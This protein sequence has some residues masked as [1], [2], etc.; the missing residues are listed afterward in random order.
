MASAK[1]LIDLFCGG[2]GFSHGAHEAGAVVVLAIDS[3]P[4]AL[5]QHY[6]NWP[7]CRHVLMKLGHGDIDDFVEQ[8]RCFV[9][10]LDG[11]CHIHGSPPCQGFTSLNTYYNN[12]LGR[13]RHKLGPEGDVNY[14]KTCLTY[15]YLEVVRRLQPVSWSMENVP[16]ALKFLKFRTPWIFETDGVYVHDKVFGYECGAPTIRAR[17]I[18]ST[19]DL[20][21][22]RIINCPHRKKL[23]E[24]LVDHLPHLEDEFSLDRRRIAV[25][26][27]TWNYSAHSYDGLVARPINFANGEGLR[28]ITWNAYAVVASPGPVNV[29]VKKELGL[30]WTLARELTEDERLKLMGFSS[31]YKLCTSSTLRCVFYESV[32]SSK[33]VKTSRLNVKGIG[34]CSHRQVIGNAVC[35]GVAKMILERFLS[36]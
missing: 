14:E 15:W 16:Y 8:L 19:S 33:L 5:A 35:P 34:K 23:Q 12:G 36:I 32:C 10:S 28:P 3:N 13:D 31:S 11:P 22:R 29:Y 18:V 27:Q 2:G 24:P 4:K 7:D 25:A 17:L 9:R 20:S 26:T 1:Y 6:Y 30:P 21:K